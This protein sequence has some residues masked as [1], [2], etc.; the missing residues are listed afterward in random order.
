MEYRVGSITAQD[1]E[2]IAAWKYP[3]PYEIYS[4]SVDVIPTLLNPT[5]R[6]FVVKDGADRRVGFCCFGS[7]ARVMGGD[8]LVDDSILDVGVGMRPDRVGRGDG[9]DFVDA[10]LSYAMKRFKSRRFRVTIAEFNQR[11]LKT[12]LSLGFN[13]THRFTRVDDNLIFIQLERDAFN[14]SHSGTT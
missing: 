12:F 3:P 11:S 2:D 13:E 14:D 6:Y 9:R 4:L 8:Y 1:A 5:N 7:E 10:I